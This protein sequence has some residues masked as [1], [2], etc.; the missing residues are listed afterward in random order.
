MKCSKCW[1]WKKGCL[2]GTH[3]MEVADD[4]R[5]DAICPAMR[6][7]MKLARKNAK[8][9]VCTVSPERRKSCDCSHPSDAMTACVD[10]LARY[11]TGG[12]KGPR[13]RRRR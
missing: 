9:G 1:L 5:N 7:V 2:D 6:A 11:A 4:F 10:C 13:R 12:G 3:R 8:A